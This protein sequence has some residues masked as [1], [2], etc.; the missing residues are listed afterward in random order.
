[1]GLHFF[2]KHVLSTNFHW[3]VKEELEN[4]STVKE[5]GRHKVSSIQVLL[6]VSV[7]VVA[8]LTSAFL[9][10]FYYFTGKIFFLRSLPIQK[11]LSDG[12]F[13]NSYIPKE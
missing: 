2:R 12:N 7:C 13:R 4:F 9:R 5:Y 8:F 11:Y 10:A 3:S 6:S 1:M